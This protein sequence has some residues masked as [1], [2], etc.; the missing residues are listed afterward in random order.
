MRAHDASP[1]LPRHADDAPR[2]TRATTTTTSRADDDVEVG[3]AGVTPA[4]IRGAMCATTR[5]A[6]RGM[7]ALASASSRVVS[8]ADDEVCERRT[9]RVRTA[10][11]CAI[12]ALAIAGGA[13]R[14]AGSSAVTPASARLGDGTSFLGKST[15]GV[16]GVDA[17]GIEDVLRGNVVDVSRLD[18]GVGARF[19]RPVSPDSVGGKAVKWSEEYKDVTSPQLPTGVHKSSS[20]KPSVAA[21]ATKIF[22]RDDAAPAAR[23]VADVSDLMSELTMTTDTNVA[24][25]NVRWDDDDDD[26]GSLGREHPSKHSSLLDELMI[27]PPLAKNFANDDDDDGR[28]RSHS[29]RTTRDRRIDDDDASKGGK[30][31]ILNGRPFEEISLRGTSRASGRAGQYPSAYPSSDRA[32]SRYPA[33]TKSSGYPSSHSSHS[34][35]SYPSSHSKSNDWE[36]S[37]PHSSSKSSRDYVDDDEPQHGRHKWYK[38]SDLLDLGEYDAETVD[39]FKYGEG[40]D[41]PDGDAIKKVVISA[42]DDDDVSRTKVMDVMDRYP[43]DDGVNTARAAQGKEQHHLDHLLDDLRTDVKLAKSHKR[44]GGDDDDE[45]KPRHHDNDDDDEK[46]KRHHDDVKSL[47]N[48]LDK[49]VEDDLKSLMSKRSSEEKREPR[50]DEAES[51]DWSDDA[52]TKSSSGTKVGKMSKE[53][54]AKYLS[55]VKGHN[56]KTHAEIKRTMPRLGAVEEESEYEDEAVKAFSTSEDHVQR[57]ATAAKLVEAATVANDDISSQSHSAGLGSTHKWESQRFKPATEEEIKNGGAWRKVFAKIFRGK[58][59]YDKARGEIFQ[60]S[61]K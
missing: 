10:A 44:D 49:D 14:G 34:S 20:T 51:L 42:E 11:L 1:L 60:D 2:E 36:S 45:K 54:A 47:A 41:L 22:H 32:S 12:G 43:S 28:T 27:K 59:S 5:R 57:R 48:K 24:K 61:G 30:H 23:D 37:F 38:Q 33:S 9:R 7:N 31:S 58:A 13:R 18:Y 56:S 25:G 55:K 4:T 15:A 26:K 21:A 3:P 53:V 35:K 16:G 52:S 39:D 8:C 6:R 46:K 29:K 19:L 40:L 17:R 50:N